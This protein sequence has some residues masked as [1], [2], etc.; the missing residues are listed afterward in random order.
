MRNLA[1]RLVLWLCDR[2]DIVPLDQ[3]R[4]NA[5]TDAIERGMRWETF[6]REAGGLADMIASLR[7]EAFEAAQEA[8]ADDDVT[9]HAWMLQDRAYR[10]LENRVVNVIAT[11]KHARAQIDE[12]E[13]LKSFKIVKSI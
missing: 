2:F 6:Y 12:T 1:I 4:L 13:R 5:G 9:R 11:G 8:A 10:A 7:R 3:M